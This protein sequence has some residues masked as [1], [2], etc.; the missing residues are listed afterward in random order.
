[1]LPENEEHREDDDSATLEAE[2]I[3][4]RYDPNASALIRAYEQL[5]DTNEI[6]RLAATMA[7]DTHRFSPKI[8]V[9]RALKLRRKVEN[10]ALRQREEVASLM[11]YRTLKCLLERLGVNNW[12]EIKDPHADEEINPIT[13]PAIREIH[14]KFKEDYKAYREDSKIDQ[15]VDKADSRTELPRPYIPC[16]LEELLRYTAD[17]REATW[18]ALKK[19]F[20]DFLKTLSSSDNDDRK[21]FPDAPP[22][23]EAR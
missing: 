12:E 18:P 5:S 2:E 17:V 14:R 19:A 23:D 13:G 9:K 11:C 20:G 22:Q 4:H 21:T 8:M 6:T 1:M 10:T 3:W 15:I 7:P 16:S